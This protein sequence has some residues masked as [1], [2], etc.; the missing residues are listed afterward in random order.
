MVR[1][2]TKS[3]TLV[4]V[5]DEALTTVAGGYKIV[6]APQSNYTAQGNFAIQGVVAPGSW[7]VSALLLQGNASSS[8]NSK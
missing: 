7:D 5:S 1:K 4:A 8:S 3:V 2:I 6:I